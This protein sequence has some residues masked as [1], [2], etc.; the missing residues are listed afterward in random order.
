LTRFADM[1]GY[2]HGV[3]LRVFSLPTGWDY[4]RIDFEWFPDPQAVIL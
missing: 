3:E 4:T 2:F 1:R